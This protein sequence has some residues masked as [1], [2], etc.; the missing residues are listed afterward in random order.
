MIFCLIVLY[1]EHMSEF[2]G[3]EKVASS[4]R[5]WRSIDKHDDHKYI[6][7]H[8]TLRHMERRMHYTILAHRQTNSWYN[9]T[10]A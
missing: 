9:R 8:I 3:A 10:A 4:G 1:L 2:S 6:F 5:W 7:K